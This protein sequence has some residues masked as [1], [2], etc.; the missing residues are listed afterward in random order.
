MERAR[1][2]GRLTLCYFA[3]VLMALITGG[4]QIIIRKSN[5]LLGRLELVY[6][7]L[8]DLLQPQSCYWLPA[9]L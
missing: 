7:M 2:S 1:G 3:L 4:L 9:I 8:I 6:D 5:Q